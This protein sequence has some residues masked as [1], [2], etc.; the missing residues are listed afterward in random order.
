MVDQ[1]PITAQR[2]LAGVIESLP[3]DIFWL[4]A[5]ACLRVAQRECYGASGRFHGAN[6]AALNKLGETVDQLFGKPSA[7]EGMAQGTAS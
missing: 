4:V 7:D 5:D 3:D 2:R 1:T 6:A